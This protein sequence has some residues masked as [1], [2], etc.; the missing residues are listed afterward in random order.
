MICASILKRLREGGCGVLLR[1][2]LLSCEGVLGACR[3][4]AGVV[5]ILT[6]HRFRTF[7]GQTRL[8]GQRTVRRGRRTRENRRA[9]QTRV[10]WS[11]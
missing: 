6:P 7:M 10:V 9:G 8:R 5:V 4:R 1:L 2:E 3:S 11:K